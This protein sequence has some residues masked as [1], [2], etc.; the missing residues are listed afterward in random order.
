MNIPA[1]NVWKIFHEQEYSIKSEVL[2]Q[3]WKWL[4]LATRSCWRWRLRGSFFFASWLVLRDVYHVLASHDS[5]GTRRSGCSR[6][7]Q[8][9]DTDCKPWSSRSS[10]TKIFFFAILW[11]LLSS[12]LVW[13]L[14]IQICQ[15]T[16]WFFLE[17]ILQIVFIIFLFPHPNVESLEGAWHLQ[18]HDNIVSR[19]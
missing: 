11:N 4:P 1:I 13:I 15:G 5:C 6:K 14:W 8:Q 3:M 19:W 18:N 16:K 17:E 7:E 12:V 10:T 2:L 9:E